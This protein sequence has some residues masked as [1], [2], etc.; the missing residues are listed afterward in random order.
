[1][2][3]LVLL[4]ED[5]ATIRYL[6]TDALESSGLQVVAVE[7]ASEVLATAKSRQPRVVILNKMLPGRDGHSVIRELRADPETA[8]A[9]IMMLTESKQRDDVLSFIKDGA[10]D[11]VVK[12]FDAQDLTRRVQLL[13]ERPPRY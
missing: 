4:V 13:L 10:D 8:G 12:P 9:R 11:Y 2:S 7:H 5:S 1:M 3:Q 6:L